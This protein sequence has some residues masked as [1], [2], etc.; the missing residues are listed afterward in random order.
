VTV[1]VGM[2]QLQLNRTETMAPGG[3]RRCASP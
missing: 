3:R 1:E 2:V